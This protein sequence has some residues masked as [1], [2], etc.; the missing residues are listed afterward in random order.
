MEQIAWDVVRTP[1]YLFATYFDRTQ[2]NSLNQCWI[3]DPNVELT[4]VDTTSPSV[5]STYNSWISSLISTYS[6]DGLRIDTVRN[7]NQDFFPAFVSAAGTY[8]VGE[9]FDG[10]TSTVCPYQSY[11][12]GVLN[13]PLYFTLVNAFQSTSG[14]MA[15]LASMVNQLKTNCSDSTIMGTFLENHDNPRFP[16]LNNDIAAAQNAIGMTMLSD[17]IPIIYQGQEQHYAGGA[18]PNNREA[19]WLSGYNTQS[20]LYGYIAKVNQLRNH[21]V[22]VDTGFTT[23]QSMVI[24]Q[25]TTTIAIR[26]G[27]GNYPV[28]GVWSNKGSKGAAYNQSIGVTGYDTGA[29]VVEIVGCKHMTAGTNG[30]LNVAMGQGAPKVRSLLCSQASTSEDKMTS[31]SIS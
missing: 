3:G 7:V 2:A 19:V 6:I 24:Y 26:K 10:S 31:R 15:A 16:S 22:S 11:V 9:I 12:P 27:T 20:T 5:K 25:D 29:A 13:Y 18:V 17:G 30:T 28:I 4:D 14:N 21:A 1:F 23:W 8:A